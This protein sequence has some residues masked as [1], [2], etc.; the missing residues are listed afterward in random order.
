MAAGLSAA[1]GGVVN[2]SVMMNS[3]LVYCSS[4]S[5]VSDSTLTS[6]GSAENLLSGAL[7]PLSSTPLYLNNYSVYGPR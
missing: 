5:S 2:V 3:D 7:E 6:L 4:T 1:D